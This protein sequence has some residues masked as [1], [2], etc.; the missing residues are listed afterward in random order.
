MP[1][2]SEGKTRVDFNAPE[3]LVER[4]D[5]IADLLG[6]SR[7]QLIV[8]AL[9]DKLGTL[10]TD[11]EY[12]RRISDAY[13]AGRIDFE[14]LESLLGT[15]EAMRMQLLRASLDR[16]PPEPQVDAEIPTD[17][18][19]YEGEVPGWTPDDPTESD[20]TTSS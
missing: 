12:K 11:E 6:I 5:A 14:T 13:Y 20:P 2:M 16:T 18:E 19:F 4:A 3:S 17:D 7:T 8:D 10:T 9:S 1:V 15:E